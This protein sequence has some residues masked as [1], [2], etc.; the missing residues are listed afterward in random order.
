MLI[1]WVREHRSLALTIVAL[2][3]TVAWAC[4]ICRSS[5]VLF[6]DS[7][8]SFRYA[9]NLA[10]GQGLVFNPGERVEG[11]TNFLWVLL[12]A[13]AGCVLATRPWDSLAYKRWT[14]LL[15]VPLL[16]RPTDYAS[17]ATT[18]LETSF[19]GLLVLALGF[20]P[21]MSSSSQDA[22]R[23]TARVVPLLAVLTRLDTSLAVCASALAL[24][25]QCW[26]S[27]R[28]SR[29]VA[30]ALTRTF[31][32]TAIGLAAYL[33]WKTAYY[34]SVLPNTYYAKAADGVHLEPGVAYFMSFIQSMPSV[35][36]LAGVIG[37]GLIV[38]RGAFERT[39]LFYAVVAM[40]LHCLYVVKVGGD[41]MEYRL[42]WEFWPLLV[43]AAIVA[44]WRFAKTLPAVMALCGTLAF[45]ASTF[46]TVLE[47][48]FGMQSL[49]R[50]NDYANLGRRVGSALGRELPAGTKVATTL[51]GMSFF[52][53]DVVVLDQWGLNDKFT[54]HMP[55]QKFI[56]TEGLNARGHLKYAPL[57]H[58]KDSG[59]NLLIDHPQVCSCS[60]P[61]SDG[62]PDVFVRVG[63]SLQDECVRT[64]YMTPTPD[65]TKWF[66]E[67][68]AEFVLVG[69]P[70]PK[71]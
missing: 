46:P 70:C 56:E 61:S 55:L 65:L 66:C 52:M 15:F 14:P 42:M 49:Q 69:V 6:D 45:I 31:A 34:G 20:V 22:V 30:L 44:S 53:P 62:K 18:G 33:A 68:P 51:A 10:R 32:P 38:A 36:L 9:N 48:R 4:A 57:S 11:Y 24:A 60:A 7:F 8:I 3:A 5:H 63:A 64:Q 1:R 19:V 2:A 47:N 59:T 12:A 35:V 58:M 40:T 39:F 50:M 23:W 27:S 26:S 25:W 16:I 29:K 37:T 43:C 71:S 28:S 17:F 67:H 41:F 13:A 21:T 54:A